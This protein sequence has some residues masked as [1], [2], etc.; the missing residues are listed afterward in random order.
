MVVFSDMTPALLNEIRTRD[1]QPLKRE[2][3]YVCDVM[4]CVIQIQ[5]Q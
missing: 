3:C 4:G 5:S 2:V 1:Y